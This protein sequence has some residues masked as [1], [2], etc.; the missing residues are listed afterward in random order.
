MTTPISRDQAQ[1]LARK[2][3]ADQLSEDVDVYESPRVI[4]GGWGFFTQSKAY[5]TDP[6]NNSG[7]KLLGSSLLFIDKDGFGYN[8][9]SYIGVPKELTS[10]TEIESYLETTYA[11]RMHP[12][13]T[14]PYKFK[15]ALNTL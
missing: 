7:K 9:L 1:L 13:Q 2:F 11:K 3:F 8:V 4:S 5:M 15:T 6:D 10:I 12:D 14:Q